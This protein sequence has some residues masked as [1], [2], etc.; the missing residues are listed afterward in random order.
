MLRA[1]ELSNYILY[2]VKFIDSARHIQYCGAP[3]ALVLE[4]LKNLAAA[5]AKLLIRIP[6]IPG[7][8]DDMKEMTAIF[9][10]IKD[11]NNI[12]FVHLLPYHN[13][14]TDKYKR[15]GMEYG[16]LSGISNDESPNMGEIM[17]L[18]SA[19]FRTKIGG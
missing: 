9:N 15:M 12:E 17:N 3:N 8:N 16:L 6:L 19:R 11:F 7:I 13:I 14:Q 5:K 2:D 4:N 1:A 18:F 10:F